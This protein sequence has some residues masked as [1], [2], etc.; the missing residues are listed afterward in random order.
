MKAMLAGAIVVLGLAGCTQ[1]QS[2]PTP[3]TTVPSASPSLQS[4]ARYP[5]CSSHAHDSGH[6]ECDETVTQT[7]CDR[8]GVTAFCD[9]LEKTSGQQQ[10][11]EDPSQ[12]VALVEGLLPWLLERSPRTSR[13]MQNRCANLRRL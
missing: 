10:Q 9:Y 7:H 12:F 8:C 11:V 4:P 5:Q 6:H 13:S 1:T 2:D 3:P